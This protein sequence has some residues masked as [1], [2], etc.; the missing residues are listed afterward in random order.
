MSDERVLTIRGNA[1]TRPITDFSLL[2]VG[3]GD[4]YYVDSGSGS[5]SASGK[6]PERALAT[7][8]AAIGKCTAN[9]GDKIYP[10]LAM[11]RL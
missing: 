1:A 11:R 2:A 3:N 10:L 7:L 5:D 9:Q 6:S 4:V 8:D